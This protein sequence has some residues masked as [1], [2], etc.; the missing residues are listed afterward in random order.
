MQPTSYQR[1]LTYYVATSVDHYIAHDD[2]TMD[3]FLLEGH[4]VTDYLSSLRDYDTVLMG[5]RT[6]QWGF[7]FGIEPGQPSPTYSHMMQYV[8]SKSM[9]Q[10]RHD[11]LQVIRDD[12]ADF[13]QKLKTE[14]GGAIYLCGGGQLASYL[15]N[16]GQIDEIILK[17]NPVVFGSGIPLFSDLNQHTCLALS[18][19]KIYDNGVLFLRYAVRG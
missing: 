10:Y 12:P 5:R 4:H 7:Q 3:G 8:F 2:E 15:M 13:V 1:K 14:K 19:A 17:V 11:Q 9:E 16:A 6:Y 18:D